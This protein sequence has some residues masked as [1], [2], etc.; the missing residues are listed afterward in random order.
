MTDLTSIII[1][2]LGLAPKDATKVLSYPRVAKIL[3]HYR[4]AVARGHMKT[5]T[6]ADRCYGDICGQNRAEGKDQRNEPR[7]W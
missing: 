7:Y 4:K 5:Y 1:H 3:A 6:A 2:R